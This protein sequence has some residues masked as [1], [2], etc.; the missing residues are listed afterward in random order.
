MSQF[1]QPCTF[2]SFFSSLPSQWTQRTWWWEWSRPTVLLEWRHNRMWR[3]SWGWRD[4]WRHRRTSNKCRSQWRR[5][6]WWVWTPERNWI[7]SLA[8]PTGEHFW[9]RCFLFPTPHPQVPLVSYNPHNTKTTLCLKKRISFT[10]SPLF[11]S[12]HYVPPFYVLSLCSP[13]LC[14]FTMSPLYSLSFA[15]LPG[16]STNKL[17]SSYIST[18]WLTLIMKLP[19]QL[20][21]RIDTSCY[22]ERFTFSSL[23]AIGGC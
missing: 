19:T 20:I 3:H 1:T 22:E 14:P 13:I 16:C 9:E 2:F 17:I 5:A 11:M 18:L 4:K 7:W 15:N 21:R 23:F 10:M 12:F 8:I 6:K